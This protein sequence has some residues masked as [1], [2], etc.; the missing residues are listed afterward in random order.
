MDTTSITS[1]TQSSQSTRTY[2][3]FCTQFCTQVNK[4]VASGCPENNEKYVQQINKILLQ[5]SE[6]RRWVSELF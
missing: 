3:S 2:E 6:E 5:L 1:P 4:Y